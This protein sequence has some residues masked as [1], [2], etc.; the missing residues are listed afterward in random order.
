MIAQTQ[1]DLQALQRSS[2]AA[3]SSLLPVDTASSPPTVLFPPEQRLAAALTEL[4]EVSYELESFRP[5]PAYVESERDTVSANTASPDDVDVDVDASFAALREHL[6]VLQS[7]AAQRTPGDYAYSAN[8][9]G[10]ARIHPAINVVREELAWAR[11]ETLA[12]AVLEMIRDRADGREHG[13]G[14]I[15]VGSDLNGIYEMPP[16]Y[17]F[18]GVTN[19]D[20][21]GYEHEAY[22]VDHKQT[23]ESEKEESHSHPEASSSTRGPGEPASGE[24]MLGELDAVTDAIERLAHIAPRL[25]NQRVELRQATAVSTSTLTS[26]STSAAQEQASG[27]TKEMSEK[28]KMRELEEIW[29]KIEKAHGKRRIRDGQRADREGWEQRRLARVGCDSFNWDCTLASKLIHPAREVPGE[30]V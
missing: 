15:S 24:K 14:M 26:A 4:L 25:Q 20:P 11:V 28:E 16:R 1:H 19:H 9:S 17:S 23:F 10:A 21:P 6:M 7:S 5:S 3:L 2:V 13:E 18:D 27:G 30:S 8:A 29:A 22:A 12:H